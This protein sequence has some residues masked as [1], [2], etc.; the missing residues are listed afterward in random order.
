MIEIWNEEYEH[1]AFPQPSDRNALIWRYQDF[2]R[3]KWLVE[4]GRLYMRRA[5]LFNNDQ[6]EGT[7]PKGEIDYLAQLAANAATPEERATIKH[8]RAE[9]AEY[10]EHFR[11]HYFVNCW[12]MAPD[13]NVAMWERY[14]SS[15][16]SVVIRSRYGLYAKQFHRSVTNVGQVTYINY[17]LSALPSRNILHRITHK[18]HFFRDEQEVRAV[19]CSE[20]PAEVK[21]QLIDPY[22]MPDG[23]GYAPKVNVVELVEAV[24]IHPDATPDF[25]TTVAVY[26][27]AHGL[28]SP[29]VSAM[30]LKPV[31]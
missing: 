23:C 8:N 25:I 6:F 4:T 31:F 29:V 14:T 24:T 12:N 3:F 18:R 19:V 2:D 11:K 28:P 22:M 26:C 15:P 1:P 13:E 10:A 20:C 7:T 17:G 21:V 9:I 30:A 16:E 5:D 27:D